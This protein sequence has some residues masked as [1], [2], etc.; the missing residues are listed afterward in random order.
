MDAVQIDIIVEDSGGM[1]TDNLT[2]RW[3]FYRNGLPRLGIG[4]SDVLTFVSVE[5]EQSHFG[6]LL[7]MR[8]TDGEKLLEGDQ[9]VI[10][11]EGVDL[12]GN[13]LEGD[14][15][16]DSPRVPLLEIIEFVPVFSSWSITPVSPEYSDI[17]QIQAIFTNEG[18]RA[19]SINVT[20]VELIDDDWHIHATSTLNLTSLDT[21]ASL[22]F[23]WEAWK[24]GTA[25]LYIYIDGDSEN[26]SRVDEFTVKGEE[27]P[28][29]AASTP[30]LIAIV[31]VLALLVVGLLS[32]IVLRKPSESMDEYHDDVWG[33]EEE[34]TYGA[35][36]NFRLDYEDDTLWN[37]V[38]RHG[39][40]DK[41]AFLAHALR[42]DRDGDGFLDAVELDR[43]A[44]DFTSMMA[45]PTLPSEVEYPFDFNDETVAHVIESHGILD[46]G[47][48]LQFARDYDE[49]QN[50]YLKHTEL[51]R[52]AADFAAS[53]HNVLAPEQTT[54]DPRLLAVAEV[55][56]ALPDWSESKINSWMDKGWTAQQIITNY[57]E[58]VQP[59][60]PTGFGEEYVEPVTEIVA[61]EP[62]EPVVEDEVLESESE[63]NSKSL[64]RLK[65][66][67]LVDLA[68][69]Q[70]IDSSGTKADIV[71]RLLG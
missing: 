48:F 52:A 70:G 65:K 20:L 41:D 71:G 53:D 60:A 43:A 5:G 57:A 23:E 36:G 69:L 58:P 44:V 30:I 39:I 13:S 27:K 24:A 28:G 61:E 37:T 55:Q 2:I 59:P 45:K 32:V 9:I 46:K 7:D 64:M 26:P 14:G 3:D 17:V 49:D 21:D 35:S 68:N 56:T 67:E 47:A 51:S 18:L 62:A 19:G 42:Y 29:G 31:G 15:T 22:V 4:G 34:N 11:F 50:G 10:W 25:E 6:N 63:S 54:P 1:P 16:E 33:D 40:Y 38:S 12:A 66:A 8:P